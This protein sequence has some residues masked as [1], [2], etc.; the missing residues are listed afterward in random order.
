MPP[1]FPD[2][3]GQRGLATTR[4]LLTSGW[5]TTQLHH[6]AARV[7]R[8]LLRGVY[9]PHR[10]EPDAAT[11]LIAAWLWAGPG[12][13]LTGAHALRRSGVAVI[14]PAPPLFM[15]PRGRRARAGAHGVTVRSGRPLR[16]RTLDGVPTVAPARALVDAGLR[17]E[18]APGDLRAATIGTLQRRLSTG[19]RIRAEL[20]LAPPN[21]TRPIRLGVAD[22]EQGAWSLPEVVLA[23]LLGR[24]RPHLEFVANPRLTRPDGVLIG[25][26]DGYLP[27]RGVAILVH[28]REH[29]DGVADDGRDLWEATIEADS[30]YEAHGIAVAAVAPTALRD[31]AERFL[32]RL[33]RVVEAQYGRP[34]PRVVVGPAGAGRSPAA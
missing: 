15:V 16:Y 13:A 30:V 20:A 11:W 26:P 22:F 32:E 4:Q 25:V 34:R 23:E 7:G 9:A 19:D 28:S 21:G 24:Y 10:G 14:C 33:D 18:L 12:S 1:P 8:V 2:V 31:H 5:S 17:G 3:P 29:H 27:T 6:L